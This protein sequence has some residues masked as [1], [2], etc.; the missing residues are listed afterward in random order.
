MPG[1]VNKTRSE[2]KRDACFPNREFIRNTVD[3]RI[4]WSECKY[5][6]NG[7]HRRKF[8]RS[9][10]YP[11]DSLK[12][13]R[14]VRL[15]N[16]LLFLSGRSSLIPL[17]AAIFIG[18]VS[19]LYPAGYLA[20]AKGRSANRGGWP[21]VRRA[22]SSRRKGS[23][24]RGTWEDELTGVGPRGS[25]RTIRTSG[26]G[27]K[28]VVWLEEN[29]TGMKG[30]NEKGGENAGLGVRAAERERRRGETVTPRDEKRGTG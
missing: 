20:A 14:N 3:E 28:M 13:T 2:G 5:R 26:K 16:F 27:R 1:V 18:L 19:S 9:P 23:E 17:P 12:F 11:S 7:S 25:E 4:D 24:P 8:G 29:E 15:V 21:S 30:G 6:A 22:G 10:I